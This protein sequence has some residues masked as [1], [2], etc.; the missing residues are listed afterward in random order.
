MSR[1]SAAPLL[2]RLLAAVAGLAALAAAPVALSDGLKQGRQGDYTLVSG[3]NNS[4][5]VDELDKLAPRYQIQLLFKRHG[6][7]DGVT[8]VN[9]RVRNTPGDLVVETRSTGPYLYVNPPAGGRFTIEAELDGETQTRTRDLV[10][11][12]YLHLEFDFGA[13]APAK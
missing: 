13:E 6:D 12:R 9:V 7:K 1:L 4:A 3:G 10:G 11:R 8:G 2:C 5:E